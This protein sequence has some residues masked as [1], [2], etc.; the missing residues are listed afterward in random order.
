M[1][2]NG[3]VQSIVGAARQPHRQF[4]IRKFLQRWRA[5]R[6][7]LNVDAIGVHVGDAAGADIVEPRDDPRRVVG[8]NA[9]D[10]RLPLR[11]R[12]NAPRAR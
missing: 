5:M 7:H 10:V 9:S 1:G 6:Q 4:G 2:A 8:V 12:G 3:L 11:R